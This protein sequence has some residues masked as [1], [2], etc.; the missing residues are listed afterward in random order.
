[1]GK[2]CKKPRKKEKMQRFMVKGLV[3]ETRRKCDDLRYSDLVILF[4]CA[5]RHFSKTQNMLRIVPNSAFCQI[6]TCNSVW[7]IPYMVFALTQMIMIRE[8]SLFF[9][10]M[11]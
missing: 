4:L 10:V 3:H 11:I 7:H 6:L 8:S 9:P 2:K 5:G 1:M